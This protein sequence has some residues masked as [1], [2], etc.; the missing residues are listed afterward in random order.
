MYTVLIYMYSS[1]SLCI[2]DSFWYQV[3]INYWCSGTLLVWTFDLGNGTSDC[4][5]VNAWWYVDVP[6]S[7]Q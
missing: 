7:H 5:V 3:S 1:N 6:C 2:F 4:G